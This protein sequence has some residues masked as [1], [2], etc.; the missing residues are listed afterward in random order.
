[1]LTDS[2]VVGQRNESTSLAT[3]EERIESQR[4]IMSGMV[5]AAICQV[6]MFDFFEVALTISPLVWNV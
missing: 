4:E 5:E 1:M 2:T 6:L 3:L